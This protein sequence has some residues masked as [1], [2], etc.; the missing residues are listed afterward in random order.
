VSTV[1]RELET[2][3]LAI[4]ELRGAR[5]PAGRVAAASRAVGALQGLTD[6]DRGVLAEALVAHGAPAAG[7]LLA[8]RTGGGLPPE[9]SARLAE[10][11]LGLGPVQAAQLTDRLE[12]VATAASPA[13]AAAAMAA[14]ADAAPARAAATSTPPDPQAT[15]GPPPVPRAAR[16][17][18]AAAGTAGR[19]GPSA[20]P[21][22]SGTSSLHSTSGTVGVARGT[23]QRRTSRSRPDAEVEGQAL[24]E[25]LVGEPS[26]RARR[27]A[28][29]A[30]GATPT[31]DVDT[32]LEV[33][34]GIPEGWQRRV[35]LR[36]VLH[37]VPVVDHARSHELLGL[38]PRPMDR[39]AT[40]ALLQR[41]GP[42]PVPAL[43]AALEPGA[44]RRLE[45]RAA[46]TARAAADG[47]A[48]Q[49]ETTC[50]ST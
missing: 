22:S 3:A 8:Q 27:Q 28:V 17:A 48:S 40:A 49:E 45:A 2:V 24:V 14:D 35:A 4:A 23:G 42:A 37:T 7:R 1:S 19:A 41:C 9:A 50:G 34:A 16:W 44:A 21:A 13:A 25:Q 36:R 26:S 46:R 12:A 32:L 6:A 29:T 18:A 11:L 5:N 15:A 10:E 47:T 31:V 39:F 38:F 43:A 30:A 20:G 33:L